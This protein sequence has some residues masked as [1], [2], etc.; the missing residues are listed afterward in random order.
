MIITTSIQA[1]N[2]TKESINNE[3]IKIEF[4]QIKEKKE[5]A[6]KII[7][8][9][10]FS[11][12]TRYAKE[13]ILGDKEIRI[14]KYKLSTLESSKK[15]DY[16]AIYQFSMLIKDF[17]KAAD[18]IELTDKNAVKNL[19]EKISLAQFYYSLGDIENS[20]KMVIDI[21][22]QSSEIKSQ[23]YWLL[24]LS[25]LKLILELDSEDNIIRQKFV[26]KT[27]EISS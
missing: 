2:T 8:D 1:V 26:S 3:K 17:K 21:E 16:Y 27:K 18:A 20:R 5:E 24:Q 14:I 4:D 23:P 19:P 11:L 9:V 10:T 13:G 6:E 25:V 7:N 22:K 15:P 12:Y